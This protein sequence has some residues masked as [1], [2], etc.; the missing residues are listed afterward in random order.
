MCVGGGVADNA[1]AVLAAVW[2]CWSW[3]EAGSW[4]ASDDVTNDESDEKSSAWELVAAADTVAAAAEVVEGLVVL[5][6]VPM[7]EAADGWELL[8]VRA[9]E[10]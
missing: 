8:P 2:L 5:T 10:G 4:G 6:A 9:K 7:V 1:G 3:L